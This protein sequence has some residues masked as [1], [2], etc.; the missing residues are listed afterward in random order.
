VLN[1]F[2]RQLSAS[3]NGLV[4]GMVD[5]VDL[6]DPRAS[7]SVALLG[8]GMSQGIHGLAAAPWASPSVTRHVDACECLS[9]PSLPKRDKCLLQGTVRITAAMRLSRTQE[10]IEKWP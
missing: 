6:I 4:P 2:H 9:L 1:E 5:C 10:E 7:T 3:A 8:E